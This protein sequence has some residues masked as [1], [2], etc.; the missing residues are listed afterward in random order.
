MNERIVGNVAKKLLHLEDNGYILKQTLRFLEED[1]YEVVHFTRIDQAIDYLGKNPHGSGIDCIITDLNME[2]EWLGE[3]Q[4]ESDGGLLSGWVWLRR[5]VYAREENL[6]IPC[7]I[8]SG[9]IPDLKAYLKS[10]NEYYLL[11]DYPVSCVSKGGNNDNGYN[12]LAKKLKEILSEI[13]EEH[14]HV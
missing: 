10:E 3:Y 12:A 14:D 5:F 11:S 2:D 7:I 4:A 13:R 1:G 9:Y 6:K 8:Y